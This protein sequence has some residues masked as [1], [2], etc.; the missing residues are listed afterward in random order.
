MNHKLIIPFLGCCF[1]IYFVSYSHT[2]ENIGIMYLLCVCVYIHEIS[3]YE[4]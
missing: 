2:H 4:D 1:N 3:L